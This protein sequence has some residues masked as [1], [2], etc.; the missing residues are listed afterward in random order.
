MG[1][2]VAVKIFGRRGCQVI[3]K[4]ANK[5]SGGVSVSDGGAGKLLRQFCVE[6][7]FWA[8]SGDGT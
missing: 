7:K 1:L 5:V 4:G 2:Q 3:A 6:A 8:I